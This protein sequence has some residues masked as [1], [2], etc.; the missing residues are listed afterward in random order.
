MLPRSPTRALA[1]CAAALMGCAAAHAGA[2][3]LAQKAKEEGCT[4]KPVRL[5][6]SDLYKCTA[7]SGNTS[8]FNV[9]DAGAENGSAPVKSSA[10]ASTRSVTV[11][12]P[13]GFPKIDANTQK[14]RDDRRRT[15]LQDELSNEEKLLAEAKVAY[16][17]GTPPPLPEERSNAQKYAERLG[18]LRQAV[19]LHERNIEALKRELG[20]R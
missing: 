4:D 7:K 11:P 14:S 2:M 10:A 18:R 6:G 9:P 1:W 12:S 5:T 16:G 8:Y 19:Q 17:D 13:S 3:T 15:V 20:A